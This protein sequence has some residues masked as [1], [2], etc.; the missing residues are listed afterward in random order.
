MYY[1]GTVWEISDNGVSGRLEDPFSGNA[2]ISNDL[3]SPCEYI[4]YV[5]DD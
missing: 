2:M 5:A 3:N 4:K 1:Y